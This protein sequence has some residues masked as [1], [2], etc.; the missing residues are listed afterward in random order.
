[1][2][3]DSLNKTNLKLLLKINCSLA[4]RTLNVVLESVK[5]NCKSQAMEKLIIVKYLSIY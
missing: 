2:Q 5:E 1:M 3:I 4:I